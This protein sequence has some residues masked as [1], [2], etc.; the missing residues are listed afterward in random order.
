MNALQCNSGSSALT[1]IDS[2]EQRK[3]IH[4]VPRAQNAEEATGAHGER[5]KGGG[6]DL[7][8]HVGLIAGPK[9]ENPTGA[10]DDRPRW[11]KHEYVA[12][13]PPQVTR[14]PCTVFPDITAGAVLAFVVQAMRHHEHTH[15]SRTHPYRSITPPAQLSSTL[16][17]DSR[18]TSC[19]LCPHR[20][21]RE[22]STTYRHTLT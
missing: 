14:E 22:G 12:R 5:Q 7:R 1:A 21:A 9:F 11:A 18:R 4:W 17:D 20:R 2:R 15:T 10:L 6:G 3:A 13:S 19:K 16:H 8:K